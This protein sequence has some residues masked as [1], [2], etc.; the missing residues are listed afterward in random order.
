M[1]NFT[2]K[3]SQDGMSKLITTE[4]T[5]DKIKGESMTRPY[6]EQGRKNYDDIFRKKKC[7]R[8]GAR[9]EVVEADEPWHD[10][11]LMCPKCDSTYNI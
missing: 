6:S 3:E 9:L 8:C 7:E 2:E 1:S 10:E 11:H 5:V 4:R